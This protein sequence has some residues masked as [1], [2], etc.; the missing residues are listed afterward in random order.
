MLPNNFREAIVTFLVGRREVLGSDLGYFIKRTFPEWN[1]K[2]EYRSLHAFIDKELSEFLEH[3][4]KQGGNDV[5][6]NLQFQTSGNTL[7]GDDRALWTLFSN[8]QR[9]GAIF[10]SGGEL[11]A[12]PAGAQPAHGESEVPRIRASE[13][14]ILL[15]KCAGSIPEDLRDRFEAILASN[16]SSPWS[17]ALNLLRKTGNPSVC[18]QLENERIDYIIGQFKERLQRLQVSEEQITAFTNQLAES[19]GRREETKKPIRDVNRLS[20]SIPKVV[21]VQDQEGLLRQVAKAAIDEMTVEQI[22]ALNLPLGLV[23]DVILA[24]R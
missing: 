16:D 20:S 5:Y 9:D 18:R 4:G 2:A 8:P 22:R 23:V 12:K 13:Y 11:I 21:A 17:A 3:V 6:R 15:R 19:R 24:R 1:L 14:A 7:S 10:V